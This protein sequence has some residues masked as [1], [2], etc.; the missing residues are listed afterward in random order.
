MAATAAAHHVLLLGGSGKVAQLLTP[1]LLQRSWTVTSIIRNPDQVADL[2]KLGDD[3]QGGGKLNVR[4]WSLEDCK[5]DD[6]AKALIDE[7]GA[8][9]VVF[10]AGAAGKGPPERVCCLFLL[11]FLFLF[12]F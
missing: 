12:F 5:S 1:M 8:D 11:F 7:V 10:S 6:Q 9:Y 2:Q 4:V 3:Q